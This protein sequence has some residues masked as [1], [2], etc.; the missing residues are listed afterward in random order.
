M[1]VTREEFAKGQAVF[2][3][4]DEGD[5]AYY[6]ERGRV[7]IVRREGGRDTTLGFVESGGLLGEMALVDNAHRY[8]TAFCEEDTTAL[9]FSRAYL[10]DAMRQAD[11]ILPSLIDVLIRR[12]RHVSHRTAQHVAPAPGPESSDGAPALSERLFERLEFEHDIARALSR[13]DELF[14]MAQPIMRSADARVAG[15]EMLLRWQHPKKGLVPP[16]SFIEA[17]EARGLMPE[18]GRWVLNEATRLA[19]HLLREDVGFVSVNVS[20]EQLVGCDLVQEVRDACRVHGVS[21]QALKLEITES[22][23]IQHPEAAQ[24]MLTA[25]SDL[26]CSLAIDDFGTGYSSFSHLHRFPLNTLKIDKSFIWSI[27]RQGRAQRLI[28]ALVHLAKDL[29]MDV[30]A[31]GVETAHHAE[32]L[33]HLGCD[34][35]QGFYY[36][37]PARVPEE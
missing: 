25:L 20:A 3:Q 33:R 37:R 13:D 7:R 16:G 19:R 9:S 26:G 21:P 6:V 2:R 32:A 27:D 31:E 5:R 1:R 12:F 29:E 36:G 10:E 11:P 24:E 15:Y 28:K 8:A 17:A 4:G 23:L 35:L 14:L 22:G 18:L 30:V 34:Y